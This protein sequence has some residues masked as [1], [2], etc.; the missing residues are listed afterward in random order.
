MIYQCK[1]LLLSYRR[2][3]HF[4]MSSLSSQ[5]MHQIPLS[6]D[7]LPPTDGL[8]EQLP[9]VM[10]PISTQPAWN[11]YLWGDSINSRST[12]C[13]NNTTP[14]EEHQEQQYTCY[15]TFPGPPLDI[16]RVRD[17]TSFSLYRTR[18]RCSHITSHFVYIND[19][20]TH[21]SSLYWQLPSR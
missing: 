11:Y 17:I 1:R 2:C 6:I 13:S 9:T 12:D 16:R 4:L 21:S 5:Q 19:R 7:Q 18:T 20:F 15:L 3:L 14:H 10:Y 8:D